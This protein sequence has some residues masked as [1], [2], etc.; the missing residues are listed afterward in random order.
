MAVS[1]T[2]QGPMD[3]IKA[4]R[5]AAETCF[6]LRPICPATL[7]LFRKYSQAIQRT[8]NTPGVQAS[9][10]RGLFAILVYSGVIFLLLF[11]FVSFTVRPSL[12]FA[13]FPLTAQTPFPGRATESLHV[14]ANEFPSTVETGFLSHATKK[15]KHPVCFRR[16]AQAL[17]TFSA[18][19]CD[20]ISSGK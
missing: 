6:P 17:S 5:E 11:Y 3:V 20:G 1:I 7:Q 18:H 15:P 8:I 10:I 2:K 13:S 14:P 19:S 12:P 16:N 9:H 4:L